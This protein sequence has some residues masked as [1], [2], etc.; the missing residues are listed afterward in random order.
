MITNPEVISAL[1]SIAA[2]NDGVI[3]PEAVVEAARDERSPLHKSFTWDDNEAAEKWRLF[4]AR[5]LLRVSVVMLDRDGGKQPIRVF[6]SLT[7]DRAEDGGGYRETVAVFENR[8]WRRQLL[9]D[10]K[11]EMEVFQRKY[12][13]ISELSEVF[14]A[15]RQAGKALA[16][17][18]RE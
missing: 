5:Q 14:R 2:K 1:R 16:Q 13:M 18:L 7:P 10:A 9:S 6:V 4:Q 15:M 17:C 11:E 3:T 12:A 8:E